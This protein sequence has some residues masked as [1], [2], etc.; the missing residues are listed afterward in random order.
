MY[1]KEFEEIIESALADGVL[2]DKKRA[3]LHKRAEAEGVDVD[4][5]DIVL[6]GRLAKMKKTSQPPTPPTNEKLGNVVKCP[7]CG[8]QV[9]GGSAVCPECGYAFSNV[10]ANSSAEKLFSKLEGYNQRQE[11]RNDNSVAKDFLS[12]AFGEEKKNH[13]YK[14]DI[15]STFPVPNT[16]AD[17]LEF[18]S[19]I[20][21]MAKS[22][23]PSSG[24]NLQHEED[25]SYAYWQLYS[26]CINKA[27]I[28]FARDAAFQPY[29]SHYDEQVNKSKS[30]IGFMKKNP[31]VV[32][33]I[34]SL[35]IMPF[36]MLIFAG[37]AALFGK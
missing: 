5:L 17:L 2:T 32:I 9:V 14:M 15:I 28:S 22:T 13:K 37:I 8:A 25:L 12:R 29:F 26:N 21:P 34:F 27:R 7:S 23:G 33:L 36:L 20:Q 11:I 18:L 1:S 6:D 19:M 31:I 3:V 24:E 30:I 35:I 4:E 16:R 10:A